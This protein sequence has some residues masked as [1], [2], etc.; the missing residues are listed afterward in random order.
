MTR[1]LC[2]WLSCGKLLNFDIQIRITAGSVLLLL[3][4]LQSSV[5]FC[6]NTLRSAVIKKLFILSLANFFWYQLF[7][8]DTVKYK[9]AV[10]ENELKTAASGDPYYARHKDRV[11]IVSGVHAGWYIGS[12]IVLNDAWYKGFPRTSFH[13]FNDSREWLQVDKIGH[14]WSAY[15]IAKY[16]TASWNWAGLPHNK[17]VWIGGIAGVCYL[18]IIEYLDGKSAKWGWS[19]ADMSAN[20]A[21]AGLFISQDLTW[22]EQRIQYKFSAHRASYTS[23]LDQ[24]ANALFGKSL[25][26]RLLKDYN[27][28]TYWFSANLSSFFPETKLPRWLNIAVGYGADGML[29]GF[30]N[31]WTDADGNTITRYDIPR[32]RQFYIAPDID[33]NRIKT[34]KKLV[35]TLLNFLNIL[36]MP[37]PALMID[38]KG[39]FRAFAFYF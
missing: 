31:K 33:F 8:Q 20:L 38:S 30:E 26:E 19:W 14:A 29:G 13:T 9:N 24:R 28:Q 12:L 37:A 23:T 27:A 1:S 25:P 39:K 32:K 36:K 4:N 11:W 18:T 16:S 17:A 5:S 2:H 34:N 3:I 22:K 21:G 7:A 35:R 10:T 15:N 6:V